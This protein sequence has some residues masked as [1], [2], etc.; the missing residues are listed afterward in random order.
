[1][2]TTY[3]EMRM[4]RNQ[5]LKLILNG[6]VIRS[7]VSNDRMISNWIGL[8]FLLRKSVMSQGVFT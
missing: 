4:I 3:D 2:K 8:S 1:M 7:E 5:K 6:L